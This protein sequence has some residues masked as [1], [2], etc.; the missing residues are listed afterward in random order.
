MQYILQR[1]LT[2]D[3]HNSWLKHVGCYAVYKT[4]NLYILYAI[5]GFVSHIKMSLFLC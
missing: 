1:H 4:T 2:E 3:G 5:V